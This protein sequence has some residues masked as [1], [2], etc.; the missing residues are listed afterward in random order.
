MSGS[1]EADSVTRV[2]GSPA[3]SQK[4]CTRAP[5]PVLLGCCDDPASRELRGSRLQALTTPAPVAV[6]PAHPA[7]T[8]GLAPRGL[9]ERGQGSRAWSPTANTLPFPP[10]PATP[11][12][13]LP[14]LNLHTFTE[15][16]GHSQ[17]VPW[18]LI[19]LRS[20]K[21]RCFSCSACGRTVSS[22]RG[23]WLLP[24]EG[25]CTEAPVGLGHTMK[26]PGPHTDSRSQSHPRVGEPG[27]LHFVLFQESAF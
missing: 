12:I 3:A 14:Y 11:V 8:A 17:D 24:G 19:S 16:K 20:Q 7:A 10:P 6:D 5:G 22:L 4:Q 21:P 25:S 23:A 13:Y 9:Q 15:G 2:A 18:K 26:A 27:K 1:L